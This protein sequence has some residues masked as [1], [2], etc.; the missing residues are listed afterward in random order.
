MVTFINVFEMH[1][2]HM[3]AFI[4]Q[5]R[6]RAAMMSTKPGFLDSRLHQALS[7]DARFQV[8]NVSHWDSADALQAAT[9]DPEFQRRIR[10]VTDDVEKP[11]SSHVALYKVVV[12]FSRPIPDRQ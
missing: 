3:D 12:D 11:V 8:V 4:K 7:P 10:A 1:S 9:A 2:E 5:W 6:E